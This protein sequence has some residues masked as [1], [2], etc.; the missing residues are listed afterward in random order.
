MAVNGQ[1][2]KGNQN[3]TTCLRFFYQN[4]DGNFCLC[5]CCCSLRLLCCHLGR[6]QSIVCVA[7]PV[8]VARVT[9]GAIVTWLLFLLFYMSSL[10]CVLLLFSMFSSREIWGMNMPNLPEVSCLEDLLI[11]VAFIALPLRQSMFL[12]WW[13]LSQDEYR[14]DTVGERTKST[15]EKKGQNK[16]PCCVSWGDETR[17]VSHEKTRQGSTRCHAKTSLEG[18]LKQSHVANPRGQK[19]QKIWEDMFKWPKDMQGTR[20]RATK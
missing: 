8:S 13:L 17:A 6:R 19:I 4:E 11:V 14:R 18:I 2:C 20:M 16:S 7:H 3:N 9:R 12:R 10:S 5:C 1:S 15:R